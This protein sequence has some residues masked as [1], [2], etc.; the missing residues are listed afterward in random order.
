MEDFEE[1][2]R[3]YQPEVFR[4]LLR[5]TGFEP[6]TAEELTQETFYQAFLSFG[7]F[8]GECS[9]RTWLFQIAKNVYAKFV[10]KESR[11]RAAVRS[12]EPMTAPP[13]A[14]ELEQQEMLTI[15]RKEIAALAEPAKSIVEYRLYAEA[16]YSEIAELLH[17]KPNTAAVIY[18]RTV[19]ALRKRMKERYGYEISA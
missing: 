19:A 10:R 15:L 14:A 1:I 9:M 3:N 5:M 7:R 8:R 2:Y 18:R 13:P 12:E 4:F 17:I 11:Q 16:G 6:Q